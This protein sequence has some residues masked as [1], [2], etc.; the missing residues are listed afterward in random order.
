MVNTHSGGCDHIR[1]YLDKQ[2]FD[3]HICHCSVCKR[4][5]GQDT[6]HLALFKHADLTVENLEGVNFQPFNDHNV[7][8]P[9]VLCTCAVCARLIMIDDKEKRVRAIVPNL[10]GY[11]ATNFP[12]TY[13]AFYD[14]VDNSPKLIDG[15]PHYESFP[16]D[17]A[18][19]DPA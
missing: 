5:T 16:P 6:T 4:A 7:D 2:P 3:I 17:F 19:P 13:H 12:A 8:G 18:L 1:T 11:D 14:C 9:L 10:M 15:L